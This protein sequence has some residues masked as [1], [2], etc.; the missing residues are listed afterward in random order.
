MIKK[1]D[2]LIL[3]TFTGPFLLTFTVVEFILLLV[4]I[5]KYMEE[6][7]GKDLGFFVY[8]KLFSLFALNI[9]PAALPLA[10]LLSSLMT[11]GGLGEHRELTAIKSAG[12]SLVR[13]LRPLF[14]L[15]VIL[16]IGLFVYGNTIVTWANLEM[17]SL[18]YDIKQ[19]KPTMEFKEGVFYNGLPGYRI[20]IGKKSGED[21]SLLNDVMIYDHTAGKGNTSVIL[22]DS[23]VMST[24]M[25]ESYLVLELFNG[26]NYS[27]LEHDKKT[28]SNERYL[29]SEFEKS[30]LIFN[31]SAFAFERTE[32]DLFKD[33]KLMKTMAELK[34]VV[35]SVEHKFDYQRSILAS[36]IQKNYKYQ[37]ISSDTVIQDTLKRD[38]AIIPVLADVLKKS[39]KNVKVINRA[40]K[41]ARAIKS[42]TNSNGFRIKHILKE[43]R[44]NEIEYWKKTAIPFSCI[45][46]FLI[47]APLG[48][49]IKKGGIGIPVI[50]SISF[51][52]LLYVI[53][54]QGRKGALYSEMTS[55]YAM[56]MS[57]IYLFP[58]GLFFLYQARKDSNILE[59]DYWKNIP[60]KIFKIN[61]GL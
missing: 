51:F 5:V 58:I 41:K 43:R 28:K 30:K 22:A 15:V 18:L 57:N 12:I 53:N 45:I 35:D 52:I 44:R 20:K 1:L 19:K 59:F 33:H 3:K 6:I 25:D 40:L 55:W 17:Y 46:L 13:I 56:W 27:E 9:V 29:R 60:K 49:I 38:V 54:E 14:V 47:G 36:K 8:I 31:L 61:G 11:F 32:K 42:F 21:G 10:I 48:A 26:N 16:T 24:M 34:A 23:G 4:N 37:S 2:K 7:S 39:S 50:I